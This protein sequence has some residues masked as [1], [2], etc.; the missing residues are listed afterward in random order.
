MRALFGTAVFTLLLGLT[1]AA[2][3]Q[4]RGTRREA[5]PAVTHD[6]TDADQVEGSIRSGEGD[7]LQGRRR[8]ARESLVRPRVTFVQEMLKSVER[9]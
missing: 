9:L 6:F 7:L 3:A 5:A 4:D 1:A 2:S 8:S